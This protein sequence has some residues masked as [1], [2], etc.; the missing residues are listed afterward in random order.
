MYDLV[1]SKTPAALISV[2]EFLPSVSTVEDMVS[3]NVN[4]TSCD[5]WHCLTLKPRSSL[6][7]FSKYGFNDFRKALTPILNGSKGWQ[8]AQ[9]VGKLD[10]ISY[11]GG[12]GK[13]P[14]HCLVI[15]GVTTKEELLFAGI[16]I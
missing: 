2:K 8:V 3:K 15:G 11:P 5:P 13:V 9:A 7:P 16:Q 12:M 14:K 10:D 4:Q 6:L 1:L